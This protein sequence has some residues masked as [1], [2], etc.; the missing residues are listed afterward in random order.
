MEL[1][2]RSICLTSA[3]FLTYFTATLAAKAQIVPDA[4]LPNNSTVTT[5]GQLHTINGGTTVGVNL[6]HSF[7]D[8]SVPTNNTAYFNN[9]PQVQNI[10]TRVTGNT[11]SDIDG[12]IRA[13]GNANLYLLNPNGITFGQ[14]A[15]LEIGGSFTGSTGSSFKF[16]DGSEFSAKNPQA[17]PLLTMSITPGL[18]YGQTDPRSMVT[19]AGRL[20]VREGQGIALQ[21]GTVSSTG[22]L[23]A[24]SGTVQVLGNQVSLLDNAKIDVSGVNGGGTVLVGGDY[25]GKGTVPNAQ[26]TFI[27]RGVTINA[28]ALQNGNGGRVIVWADK[29][30]EFYG[31][32]TAR[33]VSLSTPVGNTSVS[34]G[35]F[36][37]VSGKENLV[38]RGIVDVSALF[39][40]TGTLLLDPY[41]ITIADFNYPAN[42]PYDY[43]TYVRDPQ[44]NVISSTFHPGVQST[45]P[46]I[47]SGNFAGSSI[48]IAASTLESQSADIVLQATNDITLNQSL[49]LSHAISFSAGGIFSMATGTS[50]TASGN[51]VD[52]T[53]AGG[54]TVGSINTS[55]TTNNAGAISLTS[56]NGKITI[57]NLTASATGTFNGGE[58]KL[59]SNGDITTSSISSIDTHALSG[60]A[61]NIT[62]TANNG[63]I[64]LNSGNKLYA[65]SSSDGNNGGNVT[66]Q[67]NGNITIKGIVD[68]SGGKNGVSGT[69]KLTSDRGSISIDSGIVSSDNFGTKQG[70]NIILQALNGTIDINNSGQLSVASG[71]QITKI[72]RT[73]LTGITG[74]AAGNIELRAGNDI[75]ITGFFDAFGDSKPIN[76]ISY[77]GSYD[78]F[79]NIIVKSTN[80]SVILNGAEIS[81]ENIF[82]DSSKYAGD[83]FIQAGKNVEI[84]KLGDGSGSDIPSKIN[85]AGNYGRIS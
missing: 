62:L 42:Y 26:Q 45:L 6:Y 68:A 19:N 47:L 58:V 12:T 82:P 23:T 39:G 34:N 35:G 36:V 27:D 7:K 13:N 77:N 29:L 9:A 33:G 83:I 80:G 24:P 84:R 43:T 14:N 31:T 85:S 67:T 60:S 15:K 81:S 18:Q 28:D 4:T 40:K 3:F 56:T 16:P 51:K 25:Q 75:T 41:D 46:Q 53:G 63:S 11:A 21:G 73:F 10:L 5:T 52:I 79:S 50:I 59:Q 55:S 8:F 71:V 44:G 32:V 61:G 30:T 70:G 37:E 76:S 54:I 74:S 78:Y 72:D 69:I 64:T 48:T 17:P 57:G 49:T 2:H 1:A 66:L 20:T 65:T 22:V 38:Y